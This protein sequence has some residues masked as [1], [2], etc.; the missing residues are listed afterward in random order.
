MNL[1]YKI[2]KKYTDLRF[3]LSST[4]NIFYLFYY[5]YIYRPAKGSLAEFIDDYSRHHAPV[6]FLQVGANDGLISD[7][8][9]KF[10]KRDNWRGVMLE[11]QPEVFD[12]YLVK[13]HKKRPEIITINAA[14]DSHDGTSTLFVLN[15]STERWATGMSS[16]NK[17]VLV[18]TIKSG[19]IRSK[20]RKRGISLPDN[21]EDMIEARQIKTISPDTLLRHF[22]PEGFQ[23]LAVDTEGY[24][25][26]ILK[27]LDISKVAP[28]VI[29]YEEK[30]LDPKTAA[31]CRKYLT[32]LGYFC[33]LVGRD[34]V[35][36]KNV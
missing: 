18:D 26:E 7:P 14:L 11:P 5:R 3:Q 25:F 36:V 30:N 33:R 32:D 16:F 28:E 22:G 29:I 13:T 12:K 8:L 2:F 35:A 31:D 34:V 27:M 4:E 6:T 1:K 15:V 9:H 23:L 21:A 24:D 17:S 19:S 10:I 20:A